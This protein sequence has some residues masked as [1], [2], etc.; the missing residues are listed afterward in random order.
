MPRLES[1]LKNLDQYMRT[2][3]LGVLIMSNPITKE[4]N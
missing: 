3:L 2:T 1:R 4:P